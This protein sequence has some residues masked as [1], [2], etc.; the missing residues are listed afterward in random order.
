MLFV[1][2]PIGTCAY[3]GGLPSNLEEF[4]WSWGQMIAYSYEYLLQPN[5][6]LHLDRSRSSF[7][8][9]ARNG[10]AESFLGDWVFMLDTDHAFDP[11]ILARLVG[12]IKHFDVDVVSAVYRYKGPPY[13]PCV[14]RWNEATDSFLHVAEVDWKAQIVPVDCVG[15]GSLLVRRV[16][17]DRIR[18]ELREKPF[19]QLMTKNGPLSEDF[20]FFRRLMKL[21]IKVGLA[22]QVKSHHLRIHRVVDE[23]YDPSV[24]ETVTV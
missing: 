8:E 20:S 13:L 21:G 5:E 15:A 16:V 10:I 12:I 19:D 7:H 3:L 11:D 9:T 6:F 17:F 14:F 22:P 18:E 4:T 24:V 1:K 23:D 2:Q